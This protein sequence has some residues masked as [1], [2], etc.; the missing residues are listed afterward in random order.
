MFIQE[1]FRDI[2]PSVIP[3]AVISATIEEI[4]RVAEKELQ[5]S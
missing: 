2:S 1:Y 3:H 5:K 4:L